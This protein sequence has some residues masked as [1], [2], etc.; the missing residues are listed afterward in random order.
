M[1]V[2]IL[3]YELQFS[4]SSFLQFSLVQSAEELQTPY[5]DNNNEVSKWLLK[6]IDKNECMNK[7]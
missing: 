3:E 6:V 4:N 2:S 5:S 1:L 7:L